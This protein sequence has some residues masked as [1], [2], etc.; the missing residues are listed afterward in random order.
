MS[1]QSFMEKMKTSVCCHT[2]LAFS[3][4]IDL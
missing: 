4:F 3:L 2:K 1:I